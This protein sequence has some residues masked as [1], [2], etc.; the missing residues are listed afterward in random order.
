VGPEVSA[1]LMISELFAQQFLPPDI[2]IL[3]CHMKTVLVEGSTDI[4]YLYK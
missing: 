4:T 2:P 3:F 1:E